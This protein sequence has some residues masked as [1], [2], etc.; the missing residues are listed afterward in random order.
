M[1]LQYTA[2]HADDIQVYIAFSPHDYGPIDSP[3]QCT[4]NI[5]IWMRQD[6]LQL[7]N[8]QTEV[9]VFGAH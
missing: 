9:I 6:F 2:Y 5:N 7:N 1:T 4:E 3:C 8:N